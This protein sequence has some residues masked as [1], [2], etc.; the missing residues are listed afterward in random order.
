M[1]M[2]ESPCLMKWD[3]NWLYLGR[4]KD[5]CLS[6]A[7]SSSVPIPTEPF[8]G[9]KCTD[10]AHMCQCQFGGYGQVDRLY[11]PSA[12][13]RQLVPV[14]HQRICQNRHSALVDGLGLSLSIPV[15]SRSMP[16]QI[17]SAKALLGR[18]C[19]IDKRFQPSIQF[20]IFPAWE[21]IRPKRLIVRHGQPLPRFP[22]GLPRFLPQARGLEDQRCRLLLKTPTFILKTWGFLWTSNAP[23]S[24]QLSSPPAV[25]MR[26]LVYAW[27]L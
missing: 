12:A 19:W 18:G 4:P 8:W 24:L 3:H 21:E 6:K 7:D 14:Q 10:V 13:G 2:Q 15:W 11:F 1:L 5:Q 9:S 26:L 23:C 17:I 20:W 22:I 25:S 27:V 16:A